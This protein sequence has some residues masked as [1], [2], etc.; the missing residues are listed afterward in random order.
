MQYRDWR[1]NVTTGTRVGVGWPP[2]PKKSCSY[3]CMCIRLCIEQWC[4]DDLEGPHVLK[5]LSLCWTWNTFESS[6][7]LN[8][9]SICD[10][11]FC[12][13]LIEDWIGSLIHWCKKSLE[14]WC[15][16]LRGIIWQ[17]NVRVALQINQH[18]RCRLLSLTNFRFCS[19]FTIKKKS[20]EST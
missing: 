13:V 2:V 15:E 16:V 10:Y 17:N 11:A 18:S 5:L 8:E 20:S 9:I 19:H 7:E 1:L 6:T 12:S 3:S 14:L 4:R